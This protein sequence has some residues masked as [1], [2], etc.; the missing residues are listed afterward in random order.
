MPTNAESLVGPRLSFVLRK[1]PGTVTRSKYQPPMSTR[2]RERA[3]DNG[4]EVDDDGS[5]K[6]IRIVEDA[7]FMVYL[8]TGQCYR[9]SAEDV[10]KR[11]FD[12]EPDIISIDQANDMKTPAGRFK[13]ARN[14]AIRQKAWQQMEDQV[15]NACIGR[16]GTITAFIDGY[17][18]NGKLKEVA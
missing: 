11:G 1:L 4:E 8:P 6:E 12:R 16:I 17:D 18:P 10:V 13:L 7:G 2:A 15:I 5:N 9:L 14:D 3:E